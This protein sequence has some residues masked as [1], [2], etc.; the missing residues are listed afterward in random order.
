MLQR[1]PFQRRSESQ[2]VP[3]LRVDRDEDRRRSVALEDTM[4][5]RERQLEELLS[6][7]LLIVE[8]H[9]KKAAGTIFDMRET[10]PK[11]YT[12]TLRI[13]RALSVGQ[14]P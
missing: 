3:A 6:A 1:A 11:L 9:Q 14:A 2:G 8:R 13:R 10:E 5:A 7:L 12:L 4:N